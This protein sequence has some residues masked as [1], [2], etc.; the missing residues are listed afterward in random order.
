[1]DHG[2]EVG[3]ELVVAGGDAAEVLQLGEEPFDQ[4]ALSV[5]PFAE[6]RFPAPVALRRDVGRG[7]LV[8]DQVADAIGIVGLVRQHDG[9]RAE[10][11]EQLIGD[12]PVV[13]LPCGQPEPDRESLR[14]DDDV[15]LGCK[16]ASAA[17]ETM[18]CTPI[19]AVAAC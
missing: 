19:F 14:V 4:V 8:L 10:T 7:T 1:M 3:G 6:A 13:R 12:L 17:T 16:P 18:I 5:E 2:E 9:A 11:I 15:D